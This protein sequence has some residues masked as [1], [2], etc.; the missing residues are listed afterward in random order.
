MSTYN[1]NIIIII[2]F[3]DSFKIL[4]RKRVVGFIER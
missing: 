4:V 2:K 1:K 3:I